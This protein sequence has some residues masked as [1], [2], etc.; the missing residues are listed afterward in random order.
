MRQYQLKQNQKIGQIE[1][2]L[3]RLNEEI[4]EHEH[5]FNDFKDE[6]SK[7]YQGSRDQSGDESGLNG[8]SSR[9]SGRISQ[10]Q[11]SDV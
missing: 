3:K 11:L 4:D 10:R 5:L 9:E 7:K 8:D 6:F 2:K 1:Q